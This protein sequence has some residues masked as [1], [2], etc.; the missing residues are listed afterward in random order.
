MDTGSCGHGPQCVICGRFFT[1]HPRLGERQKCCG[2]PECR[3]E[4]KNRWQKAKYSQDA[5]FCRRAKGRVR[6]WR[7]NRKGGDG[8]GKEPGSGA[9][10]PTEAADLARV[11]SSVALLEQTLAGLLSQS[12]GCRREE[13]LRPLLVRCAARGREVLGL[14]LSG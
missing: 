8:G 14:E 5:E 4:Y 10:P 11:S 6:R 13:E 2:R 1:P 3:Q 12:T 7:W 9:G